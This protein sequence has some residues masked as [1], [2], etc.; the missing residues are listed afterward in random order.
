MHE[1]KKIY[2]LDFLEDE[3]VEPR[4]IGRTESLAFSTGRFAIKFIQNLCEGHN[5]TYQN[6]FFEFE[7]DKDEYLKDNKNIYLEGKSKNFNSAY[8]NFVKLSRKSFQAKMELAGLS[9]QKEET[10]LNKQDKK[11]SIRDVLINK[12]TP[13][14]IEEK[15]K[16][17]VGDPLEIKNTIETI[18]SNQQ[19]QTIEQEDKELEQSL[20]N[21]Q[22][23][24]FNLIS[25][26]LSMV[27]KN[28]HAGNTLDCILFQN[29]IK[30]KNLEN[31]S[32]L[33]SRLSDLIVEMIQGTDIENFKKFYSSGLP[34]AYRYFSVEGAYTPNKDHKIFIFLELSNQ[35]KNILFDKQLTFDPLCYNMKYFL[36]TTINNILSQEGIDL[37][38][39]LAFASIFPPDDLLG[40]ISIYLRGIYLSHYCRLNYNI[41]DFNKE[42]NFLELNNIQLL[43]LKQFFRGN[44]HIYNDKYF[45]LASQMYLFLTILAEKFNIRDAEKVKK[46]TEKETIESKVSDVR[47]IITQ[48]NVEEDTLL[49][50]LTSLINI[51]SPNIKLKR[52]KPSDH[53]NINDKIIAAKFFS[54]IVKK[55]EFRTENE[56]EL[57]LK[58]IYFICDPH[59]YYIS[60]NNIQNFF[61]Y[62]DRTSA[63]QK[64]GSLLENLDTFFFEIEFKKEVNRKAKYKLFFLQ[65]DYNK[66][67]IY[68][69]IISSLIN[70]LLLFFL[71]DEE[72]GRESHSLNYTINVI[73]FFQ[74]L[75]NVLYLYMFYISKYGFYISL[76]QNKLGKDHK[77]TLKEK[78]NL[79]ILD[80]FVLNDEIYLIFFIIITSILGL[81]LKYNAFLFALQ[82][83]TI[84]KFIDIIRE[85]LSAFKLK[86]FE[87]L[88]AIEVLAIII[89]FVANFEFFFLIDEFNIE[90]GDKIENFCQNLL[91]CTINIFNHGIRAGGGIGDLLEAKS[92]DDKYLYFLRFFCDLLFYIVCMLLSLNI[93][94][95]I[96]VNTF[97]QIREDSNQKEEDQ[98]NRCFI[99]N[100][101]RIEFQK[102][103]IDIGF[104]RKYEHNTNNY[105]KFFVFLWNIDEKDMDADQSFI[106]NCMK[107]KDIT[108]I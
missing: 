14:I 41:D 63:K 55:C 108:A 81:F 56:D 4:I 2:D 7:F 80:S 85:I 48:S 3:Q 29:V 8:T 62:V 17:L 23:S 33:Y 64:L 47:E 103:K 88:E 28:F 73:V 92:Y 22:V 58:I 31:L 6:K 70:M 9:E 34:K 11:K 57:Q 107:E 18:V 1:I 66:I 68:N 76:L 19:T 40:V 98:K 54:K 89:Y 46:Y 12:K 75:L 43:E 90:V 35:I 27:N 102:N 72:R 97:S 79:Y 36:F 86:L 93:I 26:M 10:K 65:I 71:K 100:I 67:N 82:L 51:G 94:S 13:K 59:Y 101:S 25:Y 38:V 20:D 106:N 49:T 60:K 45:Q 53:N 16:D 95:S 37:S 74:I 5:R 52:V 83:L 50:K 96:I 104:H 15:P 24:F 30:F 39:V 91:E 21:T 87:L 78:I 44:P 42:L 105:I 32:E 69:F 61:K 99:C 77:L 84:I